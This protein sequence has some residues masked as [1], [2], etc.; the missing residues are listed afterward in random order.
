[1]IAAI[2]ATVAAWI[3]ASRAINPER[4]TDIARRKVRSALSHPVIFDNGAGVDARS[5]KPQPQRAGHRCFGPPGIRRAM[6]SRIPQHRFHRRQ[7]GGFWRDKGCENDPESGEPRTG[8]I[9]KVVDPRGGPAESQIPVRLMSDHAVGCVDGFIKRGSGKTGNDEPKKRS[10][11]AVGE[12]LSQNSRRRR[13]SHPLHPAYSC[14]GRRS[15][16]QR[17]ALPKAPCFPSRPRRRE[18]APR[19][20]V[21][22]GVC[23]PIAHK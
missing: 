16:K 20:F 12:I 8:E 4:G 17:L 2:A 9:G 6:A 18:R 10:D 1:M 13:G 3:D 11:H 15:E 22:R 21:E 7:R 19:G 5:A 23:L 14:R